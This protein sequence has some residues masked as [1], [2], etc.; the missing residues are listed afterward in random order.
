V[1]CGT[2]PLA[3]KPVLLAAIGIYAL[4]QVK[5]LENNADELK[6]RKRTNDREE[7]VDNKYSHLEKLAHA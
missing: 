1:C 6:M 5:R 4:V 7:T 2:R 3:Q